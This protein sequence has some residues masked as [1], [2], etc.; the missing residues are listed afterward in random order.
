MPIVHARRDNPNVS[1][2]RNVA[3]ADNSSRANCA[4]SVNSF[5]PAANNSAW[6]T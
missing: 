4:Q 6:M 5:P 1:H 3:T 2:S